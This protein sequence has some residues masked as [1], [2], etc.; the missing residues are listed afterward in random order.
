VKAKQAFIKGV[1]APL[2][3]STDAFTVTSNQYTLGDSKRAYS[4]VRGPFH[5]SENL[6]AQKIIPIR[7]TMQ[8][9]LRMDYFNAFNRYQIPAPKTNASD[10]DFGT[11]SIG[12]GG[13]N[14]QGQISAIFR[15]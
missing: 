10:N 8:L 5:P 9:A 3:F 15:F 4:E 12:S 13:M 6:S 11:V 2:V 1:S 14:R 7:E